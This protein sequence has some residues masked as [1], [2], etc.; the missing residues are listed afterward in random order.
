[1]E[2]QELKITSPAFQNEGSL[3]K[4]YTCDGDETSPPLHIENIPHNTI[5]LS[6]I[7]EDPD[8]PKGLFT[9]WLVWNIDPISDIR[10][11]SRPGISGKN[12]G[13]KT[14]YYGA[15]PPNGSHRYYFYI[16]ALDTDI[17]LPA[18]ASKQELQDA[19]EGHILA[20]GSIMAKYERA[21]AT[22]HK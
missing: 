4:K 17:D 7:A 14:G 9:H 5:T 12:S 20:Q 10:E 16:F 22:V 3:P 18:G 13:G 19:M 15:C 11:G 21:G 2:V 6:L 1:M 8:A